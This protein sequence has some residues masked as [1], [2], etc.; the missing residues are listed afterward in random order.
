MHEHEHEH[1]HE[2]E[3]SHE[4]EHG[5]EH[6]H[7]DFIGHDHGYGVRGRHYHG[8]AGKAAET[9]AAHEEAIVVTEDGLETRVYLL[10]GLDCANCAAK[11]E[12]KIQAMPEVASATVVFTAKQLRVTA[13]SHEGLLEK[14]QRMADSGEDGV[15]VI[16]REENR[17]ASSHHETEEPKAEKKE[18]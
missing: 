7:T 17:P 3:H 14:R 16:P 8:K 1:C 18:L 5:H 15:T 10:E 6:R 2:H 11:I 12:A 9:A 13:G 4:H